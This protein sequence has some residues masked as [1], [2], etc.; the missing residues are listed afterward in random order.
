[1]KSIMTVLI[2]TL[3]LLGTAEAQH[4]AVVTIFTPTSSVSLYERAK[5]NQRR[6]ITQPAQVATQVYLLRTSIVQTGWM[7]VA[8]FDVTA[9]EYGSSDQR[10][11]LAYNTDNCLT[12]AGLFQN[13]SSSLTTFQ[14]SLQRK[15]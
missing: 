13:Q 2:L 1:M 12:A 15:P 14:C 9:A 3:G 8:T 6:P 11:L 10:K 7:Y 5:S 4:R